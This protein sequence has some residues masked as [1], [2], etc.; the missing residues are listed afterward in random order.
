MNSKAL[1]GIAIGI[2]AAAAMIAVLRRPSKPAVSEAPRKTVAA[3]ATPAA[4][5]SP[6]PTPI[7]IPP[8]AAAA[9]PPSAPAA[10]T[11]VPFDSEGPWYAGK[12]EPM[13]GPGEIKDL[14]EKF[15]LEQGYKMALPDHRRDII[16]YLARFDQLRASLPAIIGA[17]PDSEMRAFMLEN[18]M[19]EGT[20]GKSPAE[21]AANPPEKDEGLLALLRQQPSTAMGSAEWV[22]RLNLARQIDA[23]EALSFARES[24]RRFPQDREIAVVASEAILAAS[25]AGGAS[26]AEA[27]DARDVLIDVLGRAEAEEL[28]AINSDYRLR[29]YES[30]AA[31]MDAPGTRD[32]LE[33]QLAREADPRLKKAL[34]KA[35]AQ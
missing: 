6:E 35:L 34:E 23:A 30:M 14:L 15:G 1:A 24:A 27:G 31:D 4:S 22:R 16:E 2:V 29:A 17:E 33:K 28:R 3:V 25:A 19:P 32:F 18:T 13:L 10:A 12:D 21:L 9:A 20:E 26:K 8:S 11:P 5:P 7:P